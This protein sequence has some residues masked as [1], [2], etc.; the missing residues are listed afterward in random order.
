MA[1]NYSY[2]DFTPSSNAAILIDPY[3]V[4]EITDAM[5]AIANDAGLKS[6]LRKMGLVRAS[7]FSWEKTGQATVEVLKAF[8]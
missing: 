6:H 8:M 3:K 5:M 2:P 4:E 1:L 7:Q